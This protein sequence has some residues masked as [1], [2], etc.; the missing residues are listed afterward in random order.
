M[1]GAIGER[2][3]PVLGVIRDFTAST[4]WESSHPEAVVNGWSVK[5][6]MKHQCPALFV[7]RIRF[8]RQWR[9]WAAGH[10]Q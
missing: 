7:E 1:H 10:E 3:I 5:L 2:D 8:T 9:L 6:I 4:P